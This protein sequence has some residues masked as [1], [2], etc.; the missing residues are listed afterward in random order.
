VAA[1]LVASRG[2]EPYA[3]VPASV[4]IGALLTKTANHN[5]N[6]DRFQCVGLVRHSEWR[7]T[8]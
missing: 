1:V 4:A 8:E 2:L 6:T 3:Q 7:R 5:E